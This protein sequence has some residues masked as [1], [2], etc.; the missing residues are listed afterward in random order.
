MTYPQAFSMGLRLELLTG[1][2]FNPN[3]RLLDM[4]DSDS[5]TISKGKTKSEFQQKLSFLK[6][7]QNAISD[8]QSPQSAKVIH[9]HE[10]SYE[11]TDEYAGIL[12]LLIEECN[13]RFTDFEKHDI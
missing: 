9:E 6:D 12:D 8:A 11:S 13:E 7:L 3:E 1:H 10:N 5:W 2:D 4:S